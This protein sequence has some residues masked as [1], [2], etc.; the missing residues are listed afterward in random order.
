[1]GGELVTQPTSSTCYQV[2]DDVF[3]YY[4]SIGMT[5]SQ[6][7]DEDCNLAKAYRKS[8]KI[9]Q[10]RMNKELWLRSWYEYETLIR[11]APIYG[12][13]QP[14]EFMV[15]PFPLTLKEAKEAE[16]RER[17]RKYEESRDRMIARALESQRRF[18]DGDNH[19]RS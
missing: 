5:A 15:E 11:V 14:Q 17:L 7:W 16:E 4:L 8:F 19:G 13:K 1:M 10:K 18:K 6:F 12:G 2:F 9:Q 3:P